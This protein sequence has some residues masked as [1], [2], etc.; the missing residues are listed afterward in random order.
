VP[1]LTEIRHYI[2]LYFVERG[3][4]AI[5]GER[6]LQA[7]V[8]DELRRTWGGQEIPILPYWH[9]SILDFKAAWQR[10]GI[11]DIHCVS[12]GFSDRAQGK[13][14][15]DAI[16][17]HPPLGLLDDDLDAPNPST[18]TLPPGGIVLPG[19]VLRRDG[20]GPGIDRA[21]GLR[22]IA[23][24]QEFDG[25]VF[26]LAFGWTAEEREVAE[27]VD[28]M[29]LGLLARSFGRE[30]RSVSAASGPRALVDHAAELLVAGAYGAS[31]A[32]AG[33]A[34]ER[35]MH[36]CLSAPDQEWIAE[37]K[38]VT[39]ATVIDKVVKDRGWQDSRGRLD[40]YRKLRNDLA[41]RLGDDRDAGRLDDEALFE[42]VDDLIGWLEQQPLGTVGEGLRL[43][44]VDVAPDPEIANGQLLAEALA[45]GAA[46]AAKARTT[47]FS[48]D[49]ERIEN[50]LDGAVWV[51]VP[52]ARRK[53]T[54]WLASQPGTTQIEGGVQLSAP[55]R[56]F[57]RGLAWAHAVSTRLDE[58]GIRCS[59]L[60][61]LT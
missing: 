53:F 9:G 13:A 10:W 15:L 34:F 60:G 51:I 25:Y 29:L 56:S 21:T 48:V 35:L 30:Y 47:P 27:V 17:R 8:A 40:A 4:V 58:A 54:R 26:D 18:R 41:H 52:D 14:M 42:R 44:L 6:E 38:H 33:V 7:V 22:T 11:P 50:G 5:D 55:D 24:E 61:R 3:S 12:F 36:G 57:E 39:L 32:V 16:L 19:A 46:A 45:G 31:G 37:R 2:A 23:F 20:G 28:H 59:Y 1:L 49:G 43:E